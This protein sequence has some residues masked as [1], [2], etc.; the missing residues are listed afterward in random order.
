[1]I[2]H[3]LSPLFGEETSSSFRPSGSDHPHSCGLSHLDRG[4][5]HASGAR[6]PSPIPREW[7]GPVKE[8]G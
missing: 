1:V 6:G 2:E 3:M 8:G 4:G 5:P 7:P